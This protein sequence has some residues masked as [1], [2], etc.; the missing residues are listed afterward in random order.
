MSRV[1]VVRLAFAC[2]LGLSGPALAG[3]TLPS[4]P[5]EG[6]LVLSDTTAPAQKHVL[7]TSVK[8]LDSFQATLTRDKLIL[9]FAVTWDWE[10]PERAAKAISKGDRLIRQSWAS[11]SD[12]ALV[13]KTKDRELVCPLTDVSVSPTLLSLG[14]SLA[15]A[16]AGPEL[17]MTLQDADTPAFLRVTVARDVTTP[18]VDLRLKIERAKA[19]EFLERKIKLLGGHLTVRQ[20]EMSSRELLREKVVTYT[21]GDG[22]PID[23]AAAWLTELAV[24]RFVGVLKE[25]ALK[26]VKPATDPKPPA[27]E[28]PKEKDRDETA[29]AWDLAKVSQ[30]QKATGEVTGTYSTIITY[31]QTMTIPV[32]SLKVADQK[33]GFLNLRGE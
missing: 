13:L 32:K 16:K 23:P 5:V 29:F 31:R 10:T 20:L 4:K 14:G 28:D 25:Q 27:K 11:A 15:D 12:A 1:W 2:V 21:V 19:I 17:F 26:E 33:G 22:Q 8:A 7:S 24:K 18:E 9:D 30:F 6:G 3:P